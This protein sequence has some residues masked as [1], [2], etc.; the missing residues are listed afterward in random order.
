MKEKNKIIDKIGNSVLYGPT[1]IH[2]DDLFA[3][4][5][6]QQSVLTILRELV[7][8]EDIKKLP[9]H[10][11]D[12]LKVKSMSSIACALALIKVEMALNSKLKPETR[13]RVIESI[14][15][16]LYG[17][18]TQHVD[19]GV[20]NTGVN[21]DKE[22]MNFYDTLPVDA[23]KELHFKQKAILDE[24]HERYKPIDVDFSR[25]YDCSKIID[26]E[27]S[28]ADDTAMCDFL[29]QKGGRLENDD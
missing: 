19:V 26:A 9:K 13:L 18:A 4:K 28:S 15:D 22:T 14:E 21:I 10:L 6:R 23:L 5:K 20:S 12:Y 2:D 1:V 16:R 11:Q 24:M 8:T 7:E 25:E 3:P 27:I 17:K 29:Q